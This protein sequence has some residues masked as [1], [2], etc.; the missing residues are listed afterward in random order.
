[1]NLHSAPRYS[2][3][4][5]LPISA[6]QHLVF[7]E[8]QW[9]LIYIENIWAE[10]RLTSEGAQLHQ[11]AHEPDSETRHGGQAHP[12]HITRSLRVHSFQH[13]L[14][15]ICDVVEFH[16]SEAS[17]QQTSSN[18]SASESVP[19]TDMISPPRVATSTDLPPAIPLDNLSGLWRPFP[20][21]YK[22]GKPKFDHCDEV[23]L[24]AQAICIE[25]ML[26]VSVPNG[27]IFYGQ[28]RHRHAVSFTPALRQVT[29]Q[30]AARVHELTAI[31][32]T[33]P[34]VYEKKCRSCSLIDICMPK[35]TGSKRN[36]V[37]YLNKIIADIAA[38]SAVMPV[39]PRGEE[40]K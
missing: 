2:E 3:D 29:E 36:P 40:G 34:P 14:S 21:E 32:K 31:G 10:N 5:L 20:I 28:T 22:R 35:V 9:A 26:G 37:S 16:L 30:T 13:G 7:C 27:A 19:Q 1:M 39:E 17:S 4:D 25:E 15:G 24:C 23:Q 8:R 12:V 18:D 33:P 6:L 11:H 38:E